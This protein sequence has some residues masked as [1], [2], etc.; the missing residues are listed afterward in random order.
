MPDEP[1]EVTET[2]LLAAA[3]QYDTAVDAGEMPE[4]VST[5]EEEVVED[6]PEPEE[7]E[8][9]K[10][11]ESDDA[12]KVEESAEEE[13]PEAEDAPKESKY[14]KNEARKAKA[15]KALNERK[16]EYSRRES[17]LESREKELADR[18]SKLDEGHSHRD[19][20][21]FT[22]EDYEDS[23]ETSEEE[24]Q[25]TDAKDARDRAEKLRGI[26][27]DSE[28]KKKAD[29]FK[30]AFENTRQELMREIPDLKEKDSSLS[31]TANQVLREYPDLLYVDGGNGL[32]HAVQIAQWK[33]AATSAEG[34]ESEVK[35]LTNKLSKLEK[36]MS[37]DGGFTGERPNA[38][39]GF[40]DL[41]DKDQELFLRKAAANLDD[42]M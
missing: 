20:Y 21:G 30:S 13:T 41:S 18:Q 23:A 12:D 2:Q 33:M 14:K 19:E 38:E 7:G 34:K 31:V 35:E 16:E 17:E 29:E 28:L 24:G 15:W 8:P 6:N 22:A 42:A 39:K 32:R 4:V 25:E 26:G 1:G 5:T 10:V 40:D 37:V 11:P 9:E 27:K 36:K 3:E